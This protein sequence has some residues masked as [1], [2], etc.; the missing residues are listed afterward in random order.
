MVARILPA[1]FL[2]GCLTTTPP[3]PEVTEGITWMADLPGAER[4]G[5]LDPLGEVT[6]ELGFT[7]V[8]VQQTLGGVPVF[9]GQAIIHLRPDGTLRSITDNRFLDI[10]ADT[11]PALSDVEAVL[12]AI[13]FLGLEDDA[14]TETPSASLQILR[15]DGADRLVW[16]VQLAQLDGLLATR[17]Q[18][19]VDAHSGAVAWSYETHRIHSSGLIA[20]GESGALG[21]ALAGRPSPPTDRVDHYRDRYT[22]TEDNGGVNV[23]AGIVSLAL[24]LHAEGGSHPTSDELRE[25]VGIGP[26]AAA[27]IWDRALRHYMTDSTDFAGARAAI[28]RA[29]ADLHGT[30]SEAYRS[31]Q[32]A[33]AL[34]GVG[35]LSAA[36]ETSPGGED[37][38]GWYEPDDVADACAG[39]QTVAE[40]SLSAGMDFALEAVGEAAA[41]GWGR[42][43]A[44]VSTT[45]DSTLLVALMYRRSGQWRVAQIGY[46]HD[47]TAEVSAL[48]PAGRVRWLVA[49]EDA[50]EGI[51]YTFGYTKPQNR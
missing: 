31:A 45:S 28:L 37:T 11:T 42:H 34:V 38:S 23:N 21:V 41:S 27:R 19:F 10:A 36:S 26:E 4:L 14:L 43:S 5:A 32:D 48:M 15:R 8:R 17:P 44:C 51:S 24:S 2:L 3:L 49:A 18:A 9:G 46:T 30:N 12:A 6:D 40:G 29:A 22:G 16:V 20:H 47:G 13:D 50:P 1:V 35:A 25:V 39:H 7:H 33:W